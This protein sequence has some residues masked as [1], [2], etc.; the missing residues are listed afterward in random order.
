LNQ[1]GAKLNPGKSNRSSGKH[2]T[3]HTCSCTKSAHKN[4]GYWIF[5]LSRYDKNF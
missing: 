4:S 2:D 3:S 5:A 1:T